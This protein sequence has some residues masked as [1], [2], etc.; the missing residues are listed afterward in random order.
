MSSGPQSS[1]PSDATPVFARAP[2][3]PVVATADPEQSPTVALRA[4]A[5]EDA[6]TLGVR[7]RAASSGR[8]A[9]G[10][11]LGR[12]VLLGPVGSGGLGDV[13]AAYDPELDRRVA[14]KVL[15]AAGELELAA[16][17]AATRMLREG[18]A[19]ARLRHP[20]VV[21]VHDVGCE[22][23]RVF[24][25]ME[26]VEGGTLRR[27]LGDAP[28]S[29]T[30]I[31]EVF[32]QAGQGL[33][34]A[35]DAG[36]V[37]RDFKPAN[38]MI[39]PGGRVVVLDFGLSRRVDGELADATD[40]TD[41]GTA[42]SSLLGRAVTEHG[43]LMGTPPYMAPELFDGGVA[44]PRSDQFAF[45]V[46]LYEALY[47]RRPF[48][49]DTLE[50]HV[51]LV[52]AGLRSRDRPRREVPPWLHRV[53]LQGLAPDPEQ[54]L[55]EMRA[56]LTALQHDRRRRRRWLTGLAIALP[57]SSAAVAAAAILLRPEPTAIERDAV[58]QLADEARAAAALGHYVYPPADDPD[59]A[60]AFAKVLELEAMTGPVAEDAR[61]RAGELRTELAD[62]LAR[63][64]DTYAARP[65]GRPFASDFYG[66][67]L[68][69][70]PGRE[71]LREA[72][73]LT[74]GELA[75]LR[76]RAATRDFSPS[77]LIAAEALSALA[78][79]DET[80][81][82][83]RV[84]RVLDR[85]RGAAS[86]AARLE[87][88]APA[89]APTAPP[90]AAAAASSAAVV[91]PPT[92][93]VLA[94]APPS[95]AAPTPTPAAVP[96]AAPRDPA[97]ARAAVDAGDAALRRGEL[98]EAERSFRR[99]LKQDPGSVG[100]LLGLARVHFNR[101]EFKDMAALAKRAIELS[102]RSASAHALLGDAHFKMFRY[103]EARS[104]YERAVELGSSA[105]K[106]GLVRVR[107]A[108][109]EATPP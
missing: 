65:G 100:A 34:A 97:V 47:G 99:A 33:I 98:A 51:E 48:V 7:A 89:A 9:R 52:R 62:A 39:E 106:Q 36:L 74:P 108:L 28:R 6:P 93:A 26:F 61:A 27:W 85:R 21:V 5:D 32:L 64:G 13:F 56:M 76:D 54:R 44:S 107:A 50:R 66:A 84:A 38:V 45:C 1:S 23:D 8:L 10:A 40:G 15:R 70:D 57:L 101:R 46:S 58:A 24:I 2:A 83:K 12:Y 102:P 14:I 94:G 29:W 41:V 4:G 67:A 68:V 81:R 16:G 75:S 30:E 35:H 42:S 20:N 37:H 105:A 103:D 79:D 18:Q 3:T 31:R 63:L 72:V 53:V 69:F 17:D 49:A 71:A 22:D 73:E 86:T 87:A 25:A 19:M 80:A 43:T 91:S 104:A 78:T 109:G 96:S 59:A 77:E 82:A 95:A 88:V 60:T 92:P 90:R 11:M 55:P